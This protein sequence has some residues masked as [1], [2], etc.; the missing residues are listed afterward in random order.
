MGIWNAHTSVGNIL[1]T[2]I[3]S[4]WADSDDRNSPWG[5]SFFVPAFIISGMGVIVF[6]FLVTGEG[7]R[8]EGGE[9]REGGRR[10]GMREGVK[11]GNERGERREGIRERVSEKGKEG[12]GDN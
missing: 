4:F 2:V 9:V 5:W 8:R 1:G 12:G 7:G 11:G 10:E 6:F 3:P